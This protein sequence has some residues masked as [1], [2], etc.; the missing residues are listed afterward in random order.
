MGGGQPGQRLQDVAA[1]PPDQ[2][3]QPLT[4]Q[5]GSHHC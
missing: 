4:L 1:D 5:M 3:L 2:D